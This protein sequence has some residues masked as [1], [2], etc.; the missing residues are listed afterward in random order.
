MNELVYITGH[1]NPDTDSICSAIA[2]AELK[3][4]M[5]IAAVPVRIGNVNK[6]TEFV[7]KRFEIE[8]PEYLATVRTQVKDLNMD[9]ISPVST[10]ISIKTAWNVM[11]KNNVKVLPVADENGKLLG[12]ITL[13]EIAG[14]Y[15]DALEN[16]ILSSS[17]TPL[18]NIIDTLNAKLISGDEDDFKTTGK[19]VIAAMVPDN[20]EPFIEKGDI[21]LVGNRK[22]SQIKAIEIGA[23]CIILTC[24]GQAESDVLEL[25]REKG[26]IL[27]ETGYD[28]F[29]AAR[30]I[31]QSIPVGYVMTRENLVC[32][33]VNDFVDS[34]K[35]RM[36]Q[37]RYRS[38][39]VIDDNNR[40]KGFISRYHLISQNKKKV[41]L[42]DHNEKTQTIEGLEQAEILEII[43]H[44]RIG[45]IQTAYPVYF[46][47]ETIGSTATL[48]AEMYFQN[49]I[50]PS[51]SIAG[52]LCA[53]IISD[54]ANFKSPTSTYADKSTAS[55][56]AKIANIDI[57][58]FAVEL[59]KA[60]SS[61]YGLS[62]QKILNYD[63]KEYI[64]N[65]YKLGIGQIN[66]SDQDSFNRIKDEMLVHMK[67]VFKNNNYDM[68]LL[69]VTDVINL[70][71]DVLFV[72]KDNKVLHKAFN[73]EPD[74]NVFH[75]NGALSRKKQIVPLISGA[76]QNQF[77]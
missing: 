54:T 50:T 32:F 4:K 38:Y 46:K 16:S 48:I 27:M 24:G 67:E 41:I 26:C 69:M 11:K 74:G 49:G 70:H 33:N 2:Y 25:V 60:G 71:S 40:I 61:L 42:L 73:I 6:E 12:I 22:D 58:E 72:C 63:F 65:K 55:K 10:D 28:T 3:R 8:L 13:S 53:A 68:L 19:V 15:M 52:I 35:D 18:R 47:N 34:I 36:L 39:P 77:I 66:S 29:A 17:N 7:L 21:V 44:H 31:N 14:T 57:D 23:S 43:D 1:R 37:T 20:M 9:T 51:N 45:D 76:L 62:P 59:F 5:G 64:F 75:L 30:M 56:L